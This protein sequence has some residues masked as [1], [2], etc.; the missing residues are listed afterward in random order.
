MNP[1][2][3][4]L[5]SWAF[6]DSIDNDTQER[7][8]KKISRE[9]RFK[10]LTS[11][12]VIGEASIK[13]QQRKL[14][15]GPIQQFFNILDET[16]VEIIFPD[17]IISELCYQMG[18]DDTDSRMNCQPTDK[19]HLTY[20]ISQGCKYFI[21]KDTALSDYSLPEK[22]IRKGYTKQEVMPFQEFK[23]R[24]FPKVL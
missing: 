15:F 8:L 7:T 6:I 2:L 13:L 4:F 19:V 17:Y 14:G 24:F 9:N 16:E 10:L 12:T 11:I 3:V 21:S 23:R 1:T 18:L 20:A 22:L 5:D